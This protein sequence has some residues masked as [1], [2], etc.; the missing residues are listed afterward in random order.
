MKWYF[1]VLFFLICNFTSAR[2]H[3]HRTSHRHKHWNHERNHHLGRGRSNWIGRGYYRPKVYYDEPYLTGGFNWFGKRSIESVRNEAEKIQCKYNLTVSLLRCK[4]LKN[5]VECEAEANLSLVSDQI[6][7][8]EL[9]KNSKIKSESTPIDSQVF[10]LFPK[11][12]EWL[13]SKMHNIS[14][15]NLF[16]KP[17]GDLFGLKITDFGCFR[18]LSRLVLP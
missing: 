6:I 3:R 2:H 5:V 11:A 4:T 17:V 7:N 8:F 12:F 10:S 16:F 14:H 1:L 13:N 9:A 15:L 18:E